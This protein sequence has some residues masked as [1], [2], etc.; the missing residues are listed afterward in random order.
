[1]CQY[2]ARNNHCNTTYCICL[3]LVCNRL[4]L[5]VCLTFLG[6]VQNHA[7]NYCLAYAFSRL[8]LSIVMPNNKDCLAYAFCRLLLSVMPTSHFQAHMRSLTLQRS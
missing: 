2:A 3:F 8:S 5:H 4:A 6:T 7:N 1:M